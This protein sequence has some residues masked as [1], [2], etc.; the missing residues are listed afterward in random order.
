M[1]GKNR[2]QINV[3]GNSDV[4]YRELFPSAS[5]TWVALGYIKESDMNDVYNM[6]KSVDSQGNKIDNKEAGQDVTFTTKLMQS[7]KEQIDFQRLAAT[8]YFQIYIPLLLNSGDTQE[9]VGHICRI[10]P[11]QKLPMKPGERLI[12]ITIDMLAPSADF[13][14]APTDY[15]VTKNVPYTLIENASPIGAPTN[16][17]SSLYTAIK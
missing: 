9:I 14:A 12:D 8:K 4:F 7:Q 3:K 6:I 2:S 1:A 10:T 5:D 17:A 13:V 15:N 11:G 16:T